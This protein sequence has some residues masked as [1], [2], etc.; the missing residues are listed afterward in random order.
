M[1]ITY[2]LTHP[3]SPGFRN[4]VFKPRTAVTISISPFTGAQQVQAHQGEWWA[5]EVTLPRM[6]RAAAEEWIAFLLKL[7]GMWGTFYLGDPDGTTPRGSAGGTPLV[8]GG[9]QTGS[10]LLTDGWPTAAGVLLAGDYLQIGSGSSQRL[11]KN[12]VDADASPAGETTLDI[13]PRLRES[14]A[15]DAAITTSNCKGVFRLASNVMPWSADELSRYEISFG[16]I[17]AITI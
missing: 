3:T 11:H 2:P 10:T 7:K 14:P 5:V 13:F 16:A 15:N 1:T 17:E 4:I 9:S 6:K 12:L 8:K